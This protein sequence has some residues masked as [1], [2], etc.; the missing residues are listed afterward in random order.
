ML[1]KGRSTSIIRRIKDIFKALAEKTQHRLKE[2]LS[3][4]KKLI[5]GIYLN[6]ESKPQ[7]KEQS[8][9]INMGVMFN[10]EKNDN[11]GIYTFISIRYVDK[12]ILGSI[13]KKNIITLDPPIQRMVAIADCLIKNKHKNK[14]VIAVSEDNLS[15]IDEIRRIPEQ[16]NGEINL[17]IIR[18]GETPGKI[19]EQHLDSASA[20]IA[21][22]DKNVWSR[23]NARWMLHQA[24]DHQIPIIGYSKAFLKAGAMI[25]VYSSADDIINQTL[26]TT[27]HWI[28]TG[29]LEEKNIIYTKSKIEI[30][31][32]IANALNY[33]MRLLEKLKNKAL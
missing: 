21:V 1:R 28:N 16:K 27:E 3:N 8:L 32:N 31:Y 12:R 29:R 24:Y 9:T 5:T 26:K 17:V 6:K 15:A 18:K 25:S 22:R 10:G 13:H 4:S 33:G 19:I 30:N 2:S 7:E 20:I 11:D 23:K 14:I